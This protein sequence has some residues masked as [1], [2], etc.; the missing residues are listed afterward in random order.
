MFTDEE[1][2]LPAPWQ[3]PGL[4]SL[5]LPCLVVV[6]QML[7]AKSFHVWLGSFHF[8][9]AAALAWAFLA[10]DR[11][12]YF[13][14]LRKD[15]GEQLLPAAALAEQPGRMVRICILVVL[16]LVLI[17]ILRTNTREFAG[18]LIWSSL[19]G[20]YLLGVRSAPART[21]EFLPREIATALYLAGVTAL[22]IWANGAFPPIHLLLP[23]LLFL[24]LLFYYFCLVSAWAKPLLAEGGA[25]AC[26]EGSLV[27]LYRGAPLVLIFAAAALVFIVPG[28]E[29]ATPILTI[30]VSATVLLL[31]DIWQPWLS[32]RAARILADVALLT[33]LVPLVVV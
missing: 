24:L 17:G 33:P 21:M 23:A 30:A 18:M 10:G 3:W 16:G 22:F 31:L 1:A 5:N 4:W 15:I 13:F 8:F 26:L 7:F 32:R 20:G 29:A 9:T 11:W 19:G 2:D 12:I 28:V 14:R 25:G 6:W 27:S